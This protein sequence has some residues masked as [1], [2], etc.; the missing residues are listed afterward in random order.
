[1]SDSLNELDATAQAA[2]VATG[3]VSAREM[4]DAA[5][6]QAERVNGD[7]NAIIHP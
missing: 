4:V 3:E 6:A 2:L 1:M 5:I 7:I